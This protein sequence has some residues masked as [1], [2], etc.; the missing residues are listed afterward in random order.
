MKGLFIRNRLSEGKLTG[1]GETPEVLATVGSHH[2]SQAR[3]VKIGS[4]YQYPKDGC[5]TGAMALVR[6]RRQGPL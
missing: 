5:L 2:P 6:E 4:S 1:Y 3:R